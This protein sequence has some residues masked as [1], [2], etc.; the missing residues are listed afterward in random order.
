VHRGRLEIFQRPLDAGFPRDRQQ[1]Q[2]RV[3]G[4]GGGGDHAGGVAERGARQHVARRALG[5]EAFHHQLAAAECGSALGRMCGRDVV[6]A[7]RRQAQRGQHHR[8][9]VGG[10]LA[11]A[12]TGAG[13]GVALD[14]GQ[15]GVVDLA[16][17]MRTD[18]LEHLL[19]GDRMVVVRPVRDTAAV[20][21]DA[22]NVQPCQR[23]GRGGNGLV[24]AAQHHH[25]VEAVAVHRQLD[26]I[27]D[28]LAADQRGAHAGR[29][30]RDA[31]GDGDRV[32]LDRRAA[33][34]ADAGRSLDRQLAQVEVARAHIRPGMHHRDQRPGNRR[35]VQSG[36]AQ[37]RAGRGAVGAALD[38]V[39]AHQKISEGLNPFS[40]PGR[41]CPEGADEGRVLAVELIEA[42]LEYGAIPRPSLTSLVDEKKRPLRAGDGEADGNM[43]LGNARRAS[44]AENTQG[45]A[46]K[47]DTS[48][49]PLGKRR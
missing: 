5:L 12:G 39:T 27:G 32:E 41:R 16:G 30:H 28:H 18:G 4:T 22:G 44:G 25:R 48:V 42:H 14:G 8:H 17:A 7:H 6:E 21:R 29:T 2:H 9:R 45:T 26:R 33:G 10:E 35:V 31:V 49:Y 47:A 19:D 46:E 40:P 13:T 1:V 43:R 11:A 23:H 38:Q 34:G 24:A 37:H 3:G 15:F 20:Q 36:G